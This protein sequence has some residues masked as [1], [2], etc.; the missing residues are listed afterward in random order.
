MSE[1]ETI[2][3][4]GEVFRKILTSG[5]FHYVA[6]SPADERLWITLDST[7]TADDGLT[8]EEMAVVRAVESQR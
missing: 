4:L 1:D 3:V 8:V 6:V 7:W 2:R 5:D